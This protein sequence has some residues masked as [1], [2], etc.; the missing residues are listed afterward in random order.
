MKKTD[1]LIRFR[2]TKIRLDYMNW[3]HPSN[4]L[5]KLLPPPGFLGIRIVRK[6][7]KVLGE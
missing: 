6:G 3:T 7:A 2:I 4:H 5:E 1:K